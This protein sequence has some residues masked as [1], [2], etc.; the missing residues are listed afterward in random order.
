MPGRPTLGGPPTLCSLIRRHFL[1]EVKRE[2][3]A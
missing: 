1:D 3:K 2:P